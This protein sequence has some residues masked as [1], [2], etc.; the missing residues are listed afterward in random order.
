MQFAFGIPLKSR[1]IAKNWGDTLRV[2][3]RTLSAVLRQTNPAFRVFVGCHE[4]PDVPEMADP[5][6][7]ALSASFDIPVY[8]TEYM[9]DKHKKR[10][11]IAVRWRELGAGYLMYVDSDD[12]V[13]NRIVQHVL[14]VPPAR[15]FLA[16][17]G[18]DYSERTHKIALSPRFHRTCGTNCAINWTSD[19][20]PAT[21]FQP[22]PVLFRETV[23]VGNA[24]TA[25]LFKRRGEPLTNFPFPSVVYVREHGDNATDVLHTDGLPR[26]IIRALTPARTLP[27]ALKEEFNLN[28]P[29]PAADVLVS[30][31]R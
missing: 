30:T 19:E 24:G 23:V 29:T 21:L 16:W 17:Y 31:T 9:I 7:E 4:I 3:R 10:E 12:L 6:V 27:L 5:R 13:S 1:R 11:L 14:S 22:E 15:G 18:Y 26:R 2:F 20:L 25:A 8:K 28:S